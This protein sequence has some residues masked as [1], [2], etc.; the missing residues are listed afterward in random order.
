MDAAMRSATR[1][2]RDVYSDPKFFMRPD[3][4]Q[5][6]AVRSWR[7]PRAIQEHHRQQPGAPWVDNVRDRSVITSDARS[8]RPIRPY[9]HDEAALVP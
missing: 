1:W 2:N 9:V 7:W 3:A 4:A 8:P 6:L 5:R